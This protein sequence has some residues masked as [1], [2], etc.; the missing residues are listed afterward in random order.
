MCRHSLLLT[1]PLLASLACVKQASTTAPSE[2]DPSTEPAPVEPPS[3]VEAEDEVD[4]VEAVEEPEDPEA[5]EIDTMSDEELAALEAELDAEIEAENAGSYHETSMGFGGRG[6]KVPTVRQATATVDGPLDKDII[7]RIARAHINEV[8]SCYNAGL[9]KDP[10]VAGTVTIE[11]TIAADGFVST[12]KVAESDLSDAKVG[13][14][15]AKVAKRWQ[16]PKPTGGGEVRVL[17]PF[18]LN[19]G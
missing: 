10:T 17:Y 19:P 4:A 5:D 12:S 9:N 3:E 15:I 6:Q 13:E 11:F 14:C 7:R 2:P 16:F 8:R 18:L 1:L